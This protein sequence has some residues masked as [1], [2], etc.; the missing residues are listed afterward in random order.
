M[1][2]IT[3]IAILSLESTDSTYSIQIWN[4]AKGKTVTIRGKGELDGGRLTFITDNDL[5]RLKQNPLFSLRLS[6]GTYKVLKDK[7]E[8]EAHSV[9]K[10][11]PQKNAP[12]HAPIPA[13][14]P[15]PKTPAALPE[16]PTAD[17]KVEDKKEEPPAAPAEPPTPPPQPA[18]L[19]PKSPEAKTGDLF[20][21]AADAQQPTRKGKRY[22]GLRSRK[23][24]PD[25]QPEV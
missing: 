5:F 19:P 10:V 8:I 4:S 2:D 22:A 13:P 9:K 7:A 23:S 12:E 21:S 3:Q 14:A 24:A 16:L 20:D 11:A 17:A 6:T 18:P 1:S 15:A 25:S